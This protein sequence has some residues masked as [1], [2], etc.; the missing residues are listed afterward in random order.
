MSGLSIGSWHPTLDFVGDLIPGIIA[1]LVVLVLTYLISRL[2]SGRLERALERSGFQVN[3][4]ILLGRFL[5]ATLWVVGFLLVLNL[6]G[7][8]LTPLAAF[9]GIIGLAASL[10][11]QAVLQNLVAG[12]YLLAER[13]F[14]IGDWIAVVGPGGVNHEGRVEDIQMRT[15]HLRGRDEEL[16]LV[17]NSAIFSGVVTNRTAIGG[18]AQHV[19][20]TFPRDR[21]PVETQPRVRDLLED[22]SEVVAT[23]APHLRVTRV[24][25]DTWTAEVSLWGRTYEAVAQATWAIA[26]VFPEATVGTGVEA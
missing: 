8:G 26:H 3:I 9:I 6:I 23:P 4:A 5:W 22:L 1:A 14:A 10:S 25:A 20:V 2:A 17:P 13:P 12:I 15:T 11:L 18:I 19:S 16:I 24:D 21:D 7:V